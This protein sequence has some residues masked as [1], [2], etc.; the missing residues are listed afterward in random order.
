MPIPTE[1]WVQIGAAS[2]PVF[3]KDGTRL[4][5]LRG[6]GLPQVWVM[7]LDGG[8][9]KQLSFHDEKVGTLRRAPTSER[10]GSAKSR[11]STAQRSRGA[12]AGRPP[13]SSIVGWLG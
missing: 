12:I 9:A 5:H 2:T 4:F 10:V 3:S 7:D 8:N 6:A 13:L 11:R 1:S